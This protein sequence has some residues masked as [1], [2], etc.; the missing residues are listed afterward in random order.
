MSHHI[1]LNIYKMTHSE[2][3]MVFWGYENSIDKPSCQQFRMI[4]NIL[5]ILIKRAS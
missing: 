1:H 2:N 3:N 5:I 4:K